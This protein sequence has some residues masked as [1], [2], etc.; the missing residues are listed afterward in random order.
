MVATEWNP[1]TNEAPP[2]PEEPA[3]SYEEAI[4]ALVQ[5]LDDEDLVMRIRGGTG[6]EEEEEPE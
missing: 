1:T 2:M 3:F 5:G 4:E 6:E